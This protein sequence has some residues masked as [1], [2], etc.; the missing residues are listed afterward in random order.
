MERAGWSLSFGFAPF[1]RPVPDWEKAPRVYW[2]GSGT[3]DIA[4][5]HAN[6]PAYTD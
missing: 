4:A 6:K 1:V 5:V 3:P 2:S